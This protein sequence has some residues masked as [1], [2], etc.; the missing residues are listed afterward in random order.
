MSPGN[1][2]ILQSKGQGLDCRHGSLHSCE[3][4]LLVSILRDGGDGFQ[5]HKCRYKRHEQLHLLF[6]HC[7]F[8]NNFYYKI[9]YE[10]IYLE[11]RR[12]CHWE[13]GSELVNS[14]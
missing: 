5:L 14:K 11:S 12:P 2:F 7:K 1:S 10:I 3:C 8:L 13:L 9:K 4:W 6:S